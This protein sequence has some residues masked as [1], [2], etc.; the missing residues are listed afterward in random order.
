MIKKPSMEKIFFNKLIRDFI[1][2]KIRSNGDDCEVEVLTDNLHYEQALL[3]K[4]VEEAQEL[5]ASKTRQ[6]FLSE[7]ADLMVVLDALTALKEFSEAD[8]KT[9]LSESVTK[10]GLFKKRHFLIWASK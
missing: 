1:E 8:I 6:E 7:Y 10:K 3:K 2:E 5:A 4:V 9:A